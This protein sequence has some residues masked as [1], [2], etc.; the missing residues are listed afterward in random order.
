VA[1]IYVSLF[2]RDASSVQITAV[3]SAL[4]TRG[5]YSFLDPKFLNGA[6]RKPLR[7]I[8]SRCYISPIPDSAQRIK[9]VFLNQKH[10]FQPIVV[11][12]TQVI[13][14]SGVPWFRLPVLYRA[15]GH[16]LRSQE[17]LFQ[18][19]RSRKNCKQPDSA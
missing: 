2:M 17:L 18:V 16:R 10:F 12:A 8:S 6:N 3:Q 7:R 4:A 15:W 11:Y 19:G 1:S 14:S 13:S 5:I 9:K